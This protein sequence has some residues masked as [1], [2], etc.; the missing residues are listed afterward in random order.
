MNRLLEVYNEVNEYG[1]LLGLKLRLIEPGEVEYKMTIS[2]KHLSNPAAAHGGA[3]SSMMDAILGVAA[4]SHAAE[5]NKIV[6]TVE[7][8]LNFFAPVILGDKLI[9]IGNVEFR[10]N[11]LYY[12]EGKIHCSNRD[13][14]LIASGSGTFN[15]YPAE[16]NELFRKY[17]SSV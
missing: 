13:N 17:I 15:A 11:R 2:E 14:L 9:G 12:S 8:K 6:S 10:G 7:L 16:K 5:Q 3:I 1:R 4:L